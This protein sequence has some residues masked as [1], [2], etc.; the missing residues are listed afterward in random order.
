MSPHSKIRLFSHLFILFVLLSNLIQSDEVFNRTEFSPISTS[1][2]LLTKFI[3]AICPNNVASFVCNRNV[4]KV[5][6]YTLFLP[7][8][9]CCVLFSSNVVIF[10]LATSA[11][12]LINTFDYSGFQF[13][14]Q[15][16]NHSL[17]QLETQFSSTILLCW[18]YL[19]IHF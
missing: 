15:Q 3:H 18:K 5:S 7:Y 16:K 1:A 12:I 17:K 8:S 19:V 9:S 13:P 14:Q 10:G 2:S 4:F 11:M 6:I